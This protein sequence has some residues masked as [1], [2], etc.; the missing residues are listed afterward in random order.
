MY[1]FRDNPTYRLKDWRIVRKTDF[2]Q[3]L[4][5]TEEKDKCAIKK[6]AKRHIVDEYN[7]ELLY[8]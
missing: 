5:N 2:T 6:Q 7:F 1:T 3:P 8:I 4:W